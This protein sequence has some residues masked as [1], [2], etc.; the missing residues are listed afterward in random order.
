MPRKKRFFEPGRCYHI[1]LRGIDGRPVFTDDRDRYKFLLLL[2]E[3]AEL[4]N[5]RAHAFCLM[6][7]HIHLL[8][9]G[10]LVGQ[11]VSL[12]R[13]HGILLIFISSLS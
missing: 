9:G 1:M 13:Q 8:L 11:P 4:H 10:L 3:A 12:D 5:F 2:Q 7:N 6:T